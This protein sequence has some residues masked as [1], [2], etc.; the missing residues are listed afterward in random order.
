MIE[1][2]HLNDSWAAGEFYTDDLPVLIRYRPHL[3]NFAETGL[4]QYRMDIIWE[5]EPDTE[6][7]LPDSATLA[8]MKE[9]EDALVSVME[10]DNQ[11]IL[12][13]VITGDNERWWAWYTTDVDIAGERLNI[14]L[15]KFDPLPITI[16]SNDDPDWDE[17]TGVLEDFSEEE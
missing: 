15:A 4:Y 7:L 11:T 13:F 3:Q 5:Y 9:V 10:E 16:V 1:D 6:A 2:M 14:A 8:L 12:A 17:Y